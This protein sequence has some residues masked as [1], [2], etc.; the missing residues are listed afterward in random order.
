MVMVEHDSVEHLIK[1]P[2]TPPNVAVSPVAKAALDAPAAVVDQFSVE[3][4]HVP[5]TGLA[6]VPEGPPQNLFAADAVIEIPAMTA[7]ATPF[8]RIPNTLDL[9]S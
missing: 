7:M 8:L 9:I 3:V 5:L 6:P 2:S 4:S 1:S